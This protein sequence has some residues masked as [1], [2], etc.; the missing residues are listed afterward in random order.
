MPYIGY[1]LSEEGSIGY[2]IQHYSNVKVNK[3]S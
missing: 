3:I 1:I 2:E